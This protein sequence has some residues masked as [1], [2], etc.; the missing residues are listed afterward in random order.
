MIIKTVNAEN[1]KDDPLYRRVV[2]AVRHLQQTKQELTPINVLLTLGMLAPD[3]LAE[4][5]Q[6]R[7]PFLEAVLKA[8][9]SKVNRVLRIL[10]Q[11]T[12]QD[13]DLRTIPLEYTRLGNCPRRILVFSKSNDPNIER[14]YARLYLPR[15]TGDTSSPPAA[16]PTGG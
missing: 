3:K 9:L 14:A 2:N 10:R 8:N 4:W 15:A 7:I 5:Q 6:G 12:T 13:L 1:Y 16:G 11:H